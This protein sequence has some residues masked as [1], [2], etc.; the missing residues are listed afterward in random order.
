MRKDFIKSIFFK[1]KILLFFYCLIELI[2][3][4]SEVAIA[5]VLQKVIDLINN[6]SVNNLLIV[7]ILAISSIFIFFIS[8]YITSLLEAKIIQKF[9]DN[10]Y[11]DIYI[12]K[13]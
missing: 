10:L 6:Y 4:S 3:V 7:I 5:Y 11:D 1:N 13:Q 9:K 8:S 12:I 2:L